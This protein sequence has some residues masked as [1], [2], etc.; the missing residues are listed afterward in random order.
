MIHSGQPAVSF[1]TPTLN[2][3]RSLSA[4]LRSIVRQNYPPNK[5]ELIVAD[6][7]STDRTLKIARKFGAK[8]IPNPL[9]TGEAGKAA[10][11]SFAKGELVALVDSDNILPSRNWLKKMTAPFADPEIVGSEPWL[12][13]YRKR[14]NFINRYCALIG[15]ND[16]YCYFVGNYDKYSLLSRRWTGLKLDQENRFG[17]FKIKVT[18]KILPTIGA[19]G[20]VWRTNVLRDAVGDD[21]HL[22]DTDIPYRLSRAKPFYFAKVKTGIIHLYC[23]SLGDFCR[24]QKRRVCDF[25]S[26]EQ[27][28]KRTSSYQKQPVKQVKFA[29]ASITVLP[30]FFQSIKGFSRKADMVWFFHPFACW[31]TL[32]L[33]SSQ[34]LLAKFIKMNVNRDNWRQ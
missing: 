4:C 21:Q 9:K 25:L 32:W 15:M 12:F 3:E 13:T 27:S 31:I 18:G 5:V 1:L 17:Y 8:I 34:Y 6:G 23:R 26:L 22:F 10:A 33:Y 28:R 24:K 14:D 7:G 29:L 30:L 11:L 20:T 2:S 16:P 19:N